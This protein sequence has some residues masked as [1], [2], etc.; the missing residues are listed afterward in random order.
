MSPKSKEERETILRTSQADKVWICWSDDPWMSGR[1]R[2][3]FGPGHPKGAGTEWVV[4]KGKITFR[5]LP[6]VPRKVP[7]PVPAPFRAR[8]L[9]EGVAKEPGTE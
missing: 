5:S 8:K 9:A 1:M 3:M 2:R 7:G 6:G 4:P